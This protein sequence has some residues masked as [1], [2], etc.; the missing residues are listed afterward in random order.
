MIGELFK[1]I[2]QYIPPAPGMRSPALW[3]TE[4]HLAELFGSRARHIHA[5]VKPFVF[6]YRS[7]AHWLEVFRTYYGPMLKAFAALPD[8]RKQALEADLLAL[9]RRHNR[10]DAS[11]F[12][13][14]S[15]YLEAV[16][17]IQ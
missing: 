4:G 17:T 2:G 10:A 6:R 14:P 8:D 11:A 15:D 12:V 1:L 7:S 13:A 5:A 9:A 16:I 3:G